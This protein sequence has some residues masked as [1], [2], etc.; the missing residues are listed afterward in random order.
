MA[1]LLT[2][3]HTEL[4]R[5]LNDE[6]K[7]RQRPNRVHWQ[8]MR[9]LRRYNALAAPAAHLDAVLDDAAAVLVPMQKLLSSAAG[10]RPDLDAL[11]AR[12]SALE[13]KLT[14]QWSETL[15]Q[16]DS[17]EAAVMAKSMTSKA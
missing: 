12:I 6:D 1:P 4:D 2:E 11:E 17:L 8:T 7:I 9:N 14:Q 13:N 10:S 5:L 15:A 3:L 16:I